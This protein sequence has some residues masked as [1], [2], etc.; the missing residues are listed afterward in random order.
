[1]LKQGLRIELI[2]ADMEKLKKI[3]QKFAGYAKL[4]IE[5]IF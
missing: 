3:K 4:G 2:K 1:M 5:Y